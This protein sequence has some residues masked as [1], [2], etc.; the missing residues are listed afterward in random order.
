MNLREDVLDVIS[1]AIERV[2]P[3]RAVKDAILREGLGKLKNVGLVA[4]G[5]AAWR[6]AKAAKEALGEVLKW[7]IVITKYK[8][9]L[10]EIEGVEI[11]EAGHPIPDENTLYATKRVLEK[12][13]SLKEGDNLLFLVSGGGSALFEYP[14]EGI[15]LEDLKRVNELL[16]KSGADIV[17]MNTV[18]KHISAV[19]GGRFA[20]AVYPAF[21][22]SLILSDVLGD[23]L[24]SI[25]SGPAYPDETTYA[26]AL[27]VIDKY[28]LR[29]KM[30]SSVLNILER[31]VSGEVD[32]TP[33]RLDNVKSVIIGSVSL[34]CRYAIERAKFLGYNTLFLTSTLNCEASEAGRFIAEILKEI[35]RSS[36]P[37]S[38]PCMIVLGGETVVHVRG[39]GKGGRSQELALSSAI[40]LRGERGVVVAAVGTDGTDGP[41]DAAGGMVDGESFERMLLNGVDPERALLDNDSYNALKASG[42]LIIT[43]PTGTNVNDIVIGAVI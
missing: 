41:T 10:G 31:G 36:N 24:D 14:L 30:P 15:S 25:A 4:I 22:Y 28:G 2:L 12:V 17:E 26:D 20:K 43:G 11:Y 42:D 18:R 33:K 8:H 38:P 29:D 7:G 5:K 27:K 37:I 39:N 21:I 35:K 6:M 3:D 16:L 32:E 1:F 13:S 40:S 19:K 34:A 9:S 23:R